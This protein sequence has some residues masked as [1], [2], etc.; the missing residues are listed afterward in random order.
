M[1]GS[2][3]TRTGYLGWDVGAWH[4]DKGKSRDALV[5][6]AE[7]DGSLSRIGE[8]YWGNLRKILSLGVPSDVLDSLVTEA[9]GGGLHLDRIVVAIDTPLGWPAAFRSLLDGEQAP[10]IPQDMARNKLVYRE[11]ERHL[12]KNAMWFKFAKNRDAPLSAV[13]HMIG[14]QS[15]KG[16]ALLAT[17]GLTMDERGVWTGEVGPRTVTAIETY[18]APCWRSPDL[19]AVR[20]QV[21]RK[22]REANQDKK[23]A[24]TCALVAR[25]FDLDERLLAAPATP[26]PPREGWIWI[27]QDRIC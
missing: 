4:C 17:L 20:R 16:L 9:G 27:P 5:L 18:P 14:S 12:A 13:T 19:A 23:D 21:Q 3:Q 22:L 11:T 15:T 24:L 6:L 25:L 2:G 10:P 7:V 26:P 1:S 8:P